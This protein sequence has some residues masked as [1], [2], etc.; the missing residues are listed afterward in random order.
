M[1]PSK[2]AGENCFVTQVKGHKTVCFVTQVK[3]HHILLDEKKPGEFL[4]GPVVR[5]QRFHC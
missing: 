5:T 2:T 1:R 3:G 4:G